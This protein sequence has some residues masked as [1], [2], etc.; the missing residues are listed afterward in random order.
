MNIVYEF[1]TFLCLPATV[2][3][4][5]QPKHAMQLE[6]CEGHLRAIPIA[7]AGG[8][9]ALLDGQQPRAIKCGGIA[10]HHR[11]HNRLAERPKTAR[12]A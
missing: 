3:V 7:P 9:C 12:S 11:I 5:S 6:W 8:P 4:M 10:R 1:V 2:I